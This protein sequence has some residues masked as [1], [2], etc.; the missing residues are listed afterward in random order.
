VIEANKDRLFLLYLAHWA[1]HTPLQASREDYEALSHIDSHR[2]RVYAAMIRALDRG[3]GRVLEA[4][5]RQGLEE[6]TLVFFTSDNGGAHYIGL[7]EVNQPYRGWKISFF[8]GGIRV[9]Y[10]VKWPAGLAGGQTFAEPVHHFDIYATAAA[11]GGV[12]LPTDREIDGVDLVPHVRSAAKG[13][14]TDPPHDTLFWRSGHY[15]VVLADGWKLQ[16]NDRIDGDWLFDLNTDPTEQSNLAEREPERVAALR[17]LL[18]QHN[19]E[20]VEPLWPS[21][22]EMPVNIDKTLVEHDAP[23]DEYIYWPN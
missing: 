5:R 4:L 9:P 12:S 11:A 15:Q 21:V 23:D 8:E 16:V 18:A 19:A 1:P 6:N 20:Q 22:A 14:R 13:E 2:E 3:V 7:P 10:F 17:Q